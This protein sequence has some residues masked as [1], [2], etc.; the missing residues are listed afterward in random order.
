M[1]FN[2]YGFIFVFLPVVVSGFWLL[3]RA[4]GRDAAGFWLIVASITFYVLAGL[5]GF[6][7]LVPSILFD[8]LIAI[9]FLRLPETSVRFRTVLF[10][11]GVVANVC[12]LAYF[13]YK[14]FFLGTV[15]SLFDIHAQ[16]ATVVL[17]LGV[18]FLTF[19]KIAFLAD[20]RSGEI[21]QVRVLD[22]L[23]FT[24][25]FPRSIAGPITRY[26]EIVPQLEGIP[27]RDLTAQLSVGIA[28]FSIGLFKKAFI[29]DQLAAYVTPV[30][31]L[32]PVTVWDPGTP[33]LFTSWAA[34]LAYTFE[35][36]FDFSG[37]SDM[38]LGAARMFG[39]KLPM[40]FNSPYRATNIIEFWSCWHITLTR[41]LTSYIYTPLVLSITRARLARG[42]TTLKGVHSSVSAIAS[43]VA[44][45]TLTTMLISG[46]WHGAGWQF[47][48]WGLMH[49]I[50][51]T[52]NQTWRIL[53]PRFWRD[54]A[55]YSLIMKPLGG[56]F[57]FSAVVVALV[58]FRADS[59]SAALSILNDMLGGNGLV[60]NDI[61]V[62][63]QVGVEVPNSIVRVFL[64]LAPW[65]WVSCLLVW[66]TLL[67]NSLELLRT[68]HP[69]LDYSEGAT[70]LPSWLRFARRYDVLNPVT[71][72][73]MALICLLGVLMLNR[74][75]TFIYWNF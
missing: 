55:S 45:P 57:T 34:V 10:T 58:F 73:V 7:V 71:A 36:Y 41:F 24:T 6:V 68:Q 8:Y 49:G 2:S 51:L 54:S 39:I 33:T 17:P 20:I 13:K 60:P 30:F 23:L 29:A 64:P 61:M 44:V 18:S 62:L 5:T 19:Q 52:V 3:A 31:D 72:V 53:R 47:V 1:P 40:N 46:F 67:P 28:L 37:Y 65:I 9:S 12:F 11:T 32:G 75:Q 22:Y 16:L 25:F 14:N 48:V 59:V 42:K 74:G 50:Y 63:R 38:A 56:V 66:V 70:E 27:T 15:Y 4:F 26:N 43:S 69:A 35:L 21:Q